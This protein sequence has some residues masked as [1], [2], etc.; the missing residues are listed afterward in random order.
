MAVS[1]N[2]QYGGEKPRGDIW[3]ADI[4]EQGNYCIR[5]DQRLLIWW[6]DAVVGASIN[7]RNENLL[8]TLDFRWK[9]RGHQRGWPS[10]ILLNDNNA[11]SATIDLSDETVKF[12]LSMIP[13]ELDSDAAR[14]VWMSDHGCNRQS[15][16]LQGYLISSEE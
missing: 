12:S 11:Y 9:N 5:A 1:R 3:G 10:E 6:A 2:T 14:L 15:L 8:E 16:Q 13:L 7:L 4:S